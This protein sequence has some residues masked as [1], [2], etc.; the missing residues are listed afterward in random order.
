MLS[1]AIHLNF[2]LNYSQAGY[3]N[4]DSVSHLQPTPP[5][6]QEGSFGVISVISYCGG[7]NAWQIH[8]TS[9][10]K[11]EATSA[12]MS[13]LIAILSGATKPT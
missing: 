2:A 6:S 13:T 5:A 12:E 10:H 11:A 4:G 8:H 9:I 7:V 1:E 3:A